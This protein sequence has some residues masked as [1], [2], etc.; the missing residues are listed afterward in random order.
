M[1]SKQ[2]QIYLGQTTS[3]NPRTSRILVI[4]CSD[5]LQPFSMLITV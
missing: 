3:F 1:Q 5:G 2:S 4:D